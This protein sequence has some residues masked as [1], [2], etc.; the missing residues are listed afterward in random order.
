M[1]IA[2]TTY[3]LSDCSP[4]KPV[5]DIVGVLT[6]SCLRLN[7]SGKVRRLANFHCYYDREIQ[8]LQQFKNLA[9]ILICL[10]VGGGQCAN[11]AHGQGNSQGQE[12]ELPEHASWAVG[13]AGKKV[14][15][16]GFYRIAFSGDGRFMAGRTQRNEVKI[17]DVSNQE[18]ICT[19]VEE[20]ATISTV[21]FS[22]DGKYFLTGV[23][24]D[25]VRVYESESGDLVKEL[26]KSLSLA[27]F[28]QDGRQIV[29]AGEERV[30]KFSWPDGK[31]SLGK[32]WKLDA[33][34]SPKALSKDG[35]ILL[36]CTK[37]RH[38][39]SARVVFENRKAVTELRGIDGPFRAAQI[40]PDGR[41]IAATF[42]NSEH[43]F[44]WD[45]R[46]ARSPRYTLAGH[47]QSV[48]SLD[49]SPDSLFLISTSWDKTAVVWDLSS[50]KKLAALE[51]HEGNVNSCRFHPFRLEVATGA[52]S[53]K[54]SRI[55]LWDLESI[56]F[57]ELELPKS[58]ESFEIT[59]KVM[60]SEVPT[61]SLKATKAFMR[62]EDKWIPLAR[63]KLVS[64]KRAVDSNAIWELVLKLGSPR[65]AV[66][67]KTTRELLDLRTVAEK[68]LKEALSDPR[69]N[70][71][72]RH[73]ILRILKERIK[74]VE[75]P[76]DELRRFH[77]CILA[78]EL[79]DS[80]ASAELLSELEE[81]Q[82][83]SLAM[84]ATAALD[85]KRRR[86]SLRR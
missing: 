62:F 24:G 54:D 47:R 80:Q 25:P 39:N 28:A 46:Q 16:N 59:W 76:P 45:L 17:Y 5:N 18:Q 11:T 85:R 82:D 8:L 3:A 43:V 2:C 58:F 48:Q 13:E 50:K 32:K 77:K 26:G 9:L 56:L 23:P 68:I 42:F 67:E 36:S 10:I 15:R 72:A 61:Q 29:A 84:A 71:E 6:S 69:V 14:E 79:L 21:D 44:L 34:H 53:S 1:G 35:Q 55:I 70:A 22:P 20:G 19:I 60:G 65:F 81:H 57:P 4:S 27:Y 40:S 31:L 38:R 78:L 73:R 86:Q 49:F 51:G 33:A 74:V 75:I 83:Y 64:Q 30:E 7:D 37:G 52:S 63:T 12:M 41:W 66:R